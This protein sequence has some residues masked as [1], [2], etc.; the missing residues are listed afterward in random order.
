[1]GGKKK[2]GGGEMQSSNVGAHSAPSRAAATVSS[3]L[4]ELLACKD[5]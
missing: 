4:A 1:M 5:F 2:G 3:M